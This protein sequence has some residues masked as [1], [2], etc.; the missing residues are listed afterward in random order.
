MV[1]WE[2]KQCPQFPSLLSDQIPIEQ[3]TKNDILM[4]AGDMSQN[5]VMPLAYASFIWCI[6]SEHTKS[7]CLRKIYVKCSTFI[8]RTDEDLGPC[9]LLIDVW[10]LI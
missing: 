3:V 7:L 5:F 2:R 1:P 10:P 8:L 9:L 4:Q 6:I